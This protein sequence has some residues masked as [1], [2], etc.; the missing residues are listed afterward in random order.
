V[1]S[2]VDVSKTYPNGVQA[3]R[4]VR[5]E[6]GSGLFGL[7]GPNGAG[8]STLMRT[9]A[10]LQEP[11]SGRIALD[12]RDVLAD[13][14]ALRR[15]LGYLPQE[16]GVYPGLS[17]HALLDHLALLKGLTDRKARAEQVAALLHRTNLHA[18]RHK[19]VESFSGGMRRRFG[20]AQALL[21]DPRLVIVDEPSAGLDPEERHRLHDLLV[22]I[23]EGR[24]VILSTHIVEDVRQLCSRM[25]VLAGGR[26]LLEGEPGPLVDAL[27]GRVWRKTVA[28]EELD[29]FR[30]ALPV[31]STQLRAGRTQVQVLSDTRPDA[32]F[33][34]VAPDLE[35]VY[36]SALR[37]GNA[38]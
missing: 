19:A 7:L 33:E 2:I 37:T 21:G 27:A 6:V 30:G 35:D 13:P 22:E 11:D 14:Q 29:A 10:T 16:F 4:N 24:I 31:L 8:K 32:G 28:R 26:V 5:L 34:P 23:G 15:R 18:H 36:F 1:L 12:G 9:L 25:A 20:I 17:A 3:L 38:A